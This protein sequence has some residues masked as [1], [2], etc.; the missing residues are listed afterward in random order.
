MST[1][2]VLPLEKIIE[3]EIRAADL[4]GALLLIP[5]AICMFTILLAVEFPAFAS[6]VTL[7]GME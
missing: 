1:D 3:K 6:A 4:R 2:A 7:V 5:V